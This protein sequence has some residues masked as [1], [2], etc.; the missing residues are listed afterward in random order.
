MISR[1]RL[2]LCC[3]AS[4]L[5]NE[6]RTSSTTTVTRWLLLLR[7]YLFRQLIYLFWNTIFKLLNRNTVIIRLIWLLLF[8]HFFLR[9]RMRDRICLFMNLLDWVLRLNEGIH[10]LQHRFHL[11]FFFT[12]YWWFGPLSLLLL[13]LLGSVSLILARILRPLLLLVLLLLRTTTIVEDRG[14]FLSGSSMIVIV[15]FSTNTSRFLV[16]LLRSN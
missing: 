5:T 13:I 10:V 12:C 14:L 1:L 6:A 4:A 7:Y 9:R 2:F 15:V 11:F 16:T 3:K 8:E